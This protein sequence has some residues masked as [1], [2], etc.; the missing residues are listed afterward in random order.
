MSGHFQILLFLLF[1][2]CKQKKDEVKIAESRKMA[3]KEAVLVNEKKNGELVSDTI[4]K[5]LTKYVNDERYIINYTSSYELFIIK[6]KNDTIY[7]EADSAPDFEFKDFDGD[8]YKDINLYY[9]TNVPGIQNLLLYDK[10]DKT[11]KTVN[12][13]SYFPSPHR[14][15]NTKFY[16]SYHRNGCADMN[17]AS[18]LF[19]IENFKAIKIGSIFGYECENSGIQDG[20]YIYKVNNNKKALLEEIPIRT[21]KKYEDHKWGFMKEYWIRNYKKFEIK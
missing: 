1:I 21:L 14:I 15:N 3:E 10:I 2:S 7:K 13:F 19:Y 8:G 9:M 18:D 17:W 6:S 12:D 16:Y 20:I 4:L 5:T 11:F